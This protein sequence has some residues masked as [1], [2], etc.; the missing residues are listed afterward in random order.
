MNIAFFYMEFYILERLYEGIQCH[1]M[2]V[3]ISSRSILCC[4]TL[5]YTDWRKSHVTLP[6]SC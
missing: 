1:L 6:F 5:S 3:T 2:D 4:K